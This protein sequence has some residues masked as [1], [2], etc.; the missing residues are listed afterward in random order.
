MRVINVIA[1]FLVA[2]IFLAGCST[3]QVHHSRGSCGPMET[4]DAVTLVL[5]DYLDYGRRSR[6]EAAQLEVGLSQCLQQALKEGGQAVTLIPADE[7][8]RV[9]FPDLD[10]TFGP[11][12][13]EILAS[14]LEVPHFRQKSDAL[15]LRYLIA[16]A[17]GTTSRLIP[18]AAQLV[19][20]FLV[21]G[22]AAYNYEKTTL[23]TARITDMKNPS[24]AGQV[25]ITCVSEGYYGVVALVP[26]IVPDVAESTACKRFGREIVQFISGETENKSVGDTP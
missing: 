1:S 17:E 5:E 11:P 14:L 15:R 2:V 8:R 12:R 21:Y 23:L 22:T 18:N 6:E 7:F 9:V 10:S 4:G 26:V 20:G 16:V 24:E 3:V 13:P 25:H 19:G